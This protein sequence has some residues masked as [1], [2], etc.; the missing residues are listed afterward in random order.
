MLEQELCTTDHN[1]LYSLQCGII[2]NNSACVVAITWHKC[3]TYIA[4]LNFPTLNPPTAS[5]QLC[6][7]LPLSLP[8]YT[9]VAATL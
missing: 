8:F 3:K 2:K 9:S 6:R 4:Q 1:T 7:Q 5:E